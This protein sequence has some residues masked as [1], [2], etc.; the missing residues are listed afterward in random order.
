M[1]NYYF[2]ELS[3]ENI[4]LRVLASGDDCEN[5][6][7][8]LNSLKLFSGHERWIQTWID[9]EQ[10]GRYAILGGTY[11]PT[12]D[13]FIDPK[14]EEY[15]SWVLQDDGSWSPPTPKPDKYTVDNWPSENGEYTEVHNFYWDEESLSWKI[16]IFRPDNDI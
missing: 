9:G 7:N 12:S 13:R 2:A 15:P 14:P 3:E 10:R 11:N 4:V 6:E 16:M 5:T 1:S 8:E